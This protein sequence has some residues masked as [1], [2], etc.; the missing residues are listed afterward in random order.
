MF[1]SALQDWS[2]NWVLAIVSILAP[3]QE[4]GPHL[5]L[6]YVKLTKVKQLSSNMHAF[7]YLL[8]FT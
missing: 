3:L 8:T 5:C 6:K 4:R 1:A 2:N 7:T